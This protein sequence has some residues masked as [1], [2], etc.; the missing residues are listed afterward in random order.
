MWCSYCWQLCRSRSSFIANKHCVFQN[1]RKSSAIHARPSPLFS[2]NFIDTGKK[3]WY[4]P[5]SVRETGCYLCPW[6]AAPINSF[7]HT[8]AGVE[9]SS[10][11]P[12]G[13]SNEWA[14]ENFKWQAR[15]MSS[16]FQPMRFC[17]S[18]FS[19]TQIVNIRRML[20][21]ALGHSCSSQRVQRT[22]RQHE[23]LSKWRK[24]P[25]QN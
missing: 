12:H 16:T 20:V 3:N 25:N 7:T 2:I 6:H 17:F 4:A 8:L 22:T 5:M 23:T 9:N 19:A 13:L 11:V 18:S 15:F 24:C 10:D 21:P 1:V 14:N